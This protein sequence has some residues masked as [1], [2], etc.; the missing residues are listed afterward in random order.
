[1][2]RSRRCSATHTLQDM[3]CFGDHV[4]RCLR[5]DAVHARFAGTGPWTKD[6]KLLPGEA[7]V[8][9]RVLVDRSV[10]EVFVAGGRATLLGRNYAAVGH[11]A[12]HMRAAGPAPVLLTNYSVWGMGCGWL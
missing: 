4:C 6:F 10:V 8:A 5:S 9:L 7:S 3:C 2:S 11:T 1:M 12:V